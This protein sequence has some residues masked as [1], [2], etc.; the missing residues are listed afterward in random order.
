V[1]VI[2]VALAPFVAS[3]VVVPP[4]SA[5]GAWKQL[6]AAVASRPGR[7]LHFFRIDAAAPKALAIVVT[8]GSAQPVRLFWWSDCEQESDDGMTAQHQQTVTGSHL[9]VAYPPV[10]GG[11]TQCYVT[12][13]AS[14]GR[15]AVVHAAVFAY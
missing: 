13:N 6:G 1:R 11:A 8:S 4:P 12:V 2:R 5:P 15:A 10:F 14:A 3:L 7:A 9:V